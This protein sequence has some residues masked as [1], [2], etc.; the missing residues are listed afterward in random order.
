MDAQP[1]AIE[2][3]QVVRTSPWLA[4]SRN[5]PPRLTGLRNNAPQLVDTGSTDSTMD[6]QAVAIEDSNVGTSCNWL[7]NSRN[8]PPRHTSLRDDAP[9]VVDTGSIFATMDAQA[10][11]IEDSNVVT[12]STWLFAGRRYHRPRL[13]CLRGDAPQVV[14]DDTPPFTTMD[15][16]AVTIEDSDVPITSNWLAANRRDH[17]PRLTS[18]RDDAPQVVEDDNRPP[19]LTTMDAQ[20]VAIE[21]S[22]VVTSKTW[23]FTTRRDHHPRLTCL[24]DDAPQI[25]EARTRPI[26]SAGATMDAQAVAIK[27]S[28]G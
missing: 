9:Q 13:T 4:D 5:P 1:V 3:S 12:S 6:A 18:L 17:R 28:N 27:H 11:P 10:L 20:A 2:D 8:P 21:D 15:A 23:L 16:Q 22:N 25:V 14:Q 26:L 7:A 19:P 24:R